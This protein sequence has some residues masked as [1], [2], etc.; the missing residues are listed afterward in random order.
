MHAPRTVPGNGYQC[1]MVEMYMLAHQLHTA[2]CRLMC[3]QLG[4]PHCRPVFQPCAPSCHTL[5]WYQGL[6]E[7]L[8]QCQLLCTPELFGG[9]ISCE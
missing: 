8:P 3:N 6:L 1:T 5:A 9:G 4:N 2:L 7:R